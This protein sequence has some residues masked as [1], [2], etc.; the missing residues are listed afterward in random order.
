MCEHIFYFARYYY[1]KK[2]PSSRSHREPRRQRS[3]S[4]RAPLSSNYRSNGASR[5]G[6]PTPTSICRLA[7]IQLP[8]RQLPRWYTCGR[9]IASVIPVRLLYA[10]FLSLSLAS[11][12]LFHASLS[13]ACTSTSRLSFSS[14]LPP[15]RDRPFRVPCTSPFHDTPRD[16]KIIGNCV[17][18]HCANSHDGAD[19]R[20]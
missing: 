19:D 9:F 3:F 5:C 2:K 11:R 7:L 13:I 15:R 8:R 18:L 10:P 16:E 12:S 1:L 4:Q 20:P 14:T 17:L 6:D